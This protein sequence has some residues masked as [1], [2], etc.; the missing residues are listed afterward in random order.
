V[1]QGFHAEAG[2][3]VAGVDQLT[4]VVV[5]AEQQRPDAALAAA[6]PRRPPAD[7]D[8]LHPDVLGL[9]PVP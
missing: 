2:A 6:L 5:D 7:D 4:V 8:L 1:R 9:Q 3:D